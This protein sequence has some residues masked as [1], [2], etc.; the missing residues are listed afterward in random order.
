MRGPC[1][2]RP[3]TGGE[4]G[5]GGEPVTGRL[6]R[7][8]RRAPVAAGARRVPQP[9]TG[10]AALTA[11]E[12]RVVDLAVEGHSNAETDAVLHLARRTVETHLASAYRKLAAILSRGLLD[13]TSSR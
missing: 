6:V 7:E 11:A 13:A 2:G 3:A 4:P 8:A 5:R 12:R 1:P 9:R 10:R